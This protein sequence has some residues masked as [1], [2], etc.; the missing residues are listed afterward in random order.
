MSKL[1]ED[2]F[3][4]WDEMKR[5]VNGYNKTGRSAARGE[6]AMQGC[7]DGRQCPSVGFL[8]ERLEEI[9]LI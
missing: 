8:N 1:Q 6:R 7:V 4:V 5:A 3:P 9:M 2:M